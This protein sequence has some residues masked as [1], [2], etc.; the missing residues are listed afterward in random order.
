[1][2][3]ID[4]NLIMAGIFYGSIDFDLSPNSQFLLTSQGT[5]DRCLV[6]FSQCSPPTSL[7]AIQGINAVCSGESVTYT[8]TDQQWADSYEWTLPGGWLG[9]SN[10]NSITLTAGVSGGVISVSASN[11]CGEA[12]PV[13][14]LNAS[15]TTIS[16]DVTL[17]ANT[18]TSSQ[19]SATW[20]WIDCNNN[21]APVQGA[22]GQSF[23]PLVT[24][25]YAV[26]VTKNGCT[27]TSA[28]IEVVVTDVGEVDAQGVVSIHPNPTNDVLYIKSSLGL[29]QLYLSDLNGKRIMGFSGLQISTMRLDVGNVP[30]GIYLLT[31]RNAQGFDSRHKIIVE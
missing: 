6:K 20:Q 25:S 30:A 22:T 11:Q 4:E 31:I 13:S 23:T 18:L 14:S 19:G 12:S 10:T 24:G 3:D 26:V 15:V 27:E 5:Q 1:L 17:N 2:V 8:V 28:C 29:N 21:D 7:G 16:A 9:T